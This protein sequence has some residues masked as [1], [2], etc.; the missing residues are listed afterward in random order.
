MKCSVLPSTRTLPASSR[1]GLP[2]TR[3]RARPAMSAGMP[4][5]RLVSPPVPKG[6]RPSTDSVGIGSPPSKKPFR[7][8]FSVPSPPSATTSGCDFLTASRAMVVASPGPVVSA[9]ANFSPAS[10]RVAATLGQLRPTRPAAAAGEVGVAEMPEREPR[11]AEDPLHLAVEGRQ[12]I[13]TR[14]HLDRVDERARRLEGLP[15][16]VGRELEA[17]FPP[18]LELARAEVAASADQA[19]HD[20]LL[21][22]GHLRLAGQADDE[23]AALGRRSLKRSVL[24]VVG[25]PYKRSQARVY[26]LAH[27]LDI[28]VKRGLLA[29]GAGRD[30]AANGCVGQ[31]ARIVAQSQAPAIEFLFELEPIG[32]RLHSDSQV[33]LVDLQDPVQARQVQADFA[34]ANL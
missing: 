23:E 17:A 21:C 27:R 29:R 34:G 15:E 28:P 1:R 6:T 19:L 30:Q 16:P 9:S 33:C 25:A 26:D 14:G 18:A 7:T 2:S 4:S 13:P 12:A 10:R 8:S 24:T 31:R 20:S 32:A 3:M 11:P 22:G 5:V